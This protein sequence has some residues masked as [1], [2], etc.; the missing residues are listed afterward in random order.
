MAMIP[1]TPENLAAI[2]AAY[3]K[4]QNQMINLSARYNAER[5]HEDINDYLPVIQKELPA[6]FK[7][8]RMT[9]RPFGFEFNIGT[10]ALYNMN[11]SGRQYKWSRLK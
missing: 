2:Q 5:G 9:K 11:I 8:T 10:D 7:I 1:T 3:V 6:N 4:I